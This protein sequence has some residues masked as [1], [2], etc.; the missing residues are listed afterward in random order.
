MVCRVTMDGSNPMAEGVLS[1]RRKRI[2]SSTSAQKCAQQSPSMS[3][4]QRPQRSVHRFVWKQG[5]SNLLVHRHYNDTSLVRVYRIYPIFETHHDAS[6]LGRNAKKT[7]R[8]CLLVGLQWRARSLL[9]EFDLHKSPSFHTGCT[10]ENVV[11]PN[12]SEY[13]EPSFEKKTV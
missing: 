10:E 11:N 13:S 12:F 8:N 9:I 6:K 7:C 2:H 3:E 5:T 1:G 4:F